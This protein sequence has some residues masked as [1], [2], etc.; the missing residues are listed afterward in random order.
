MECEN[1]TILLLAGFIPSLSKNIMDKLNI[2]SIDLNKLK[3]N[4]WETSCFYYL[5]SGAGT[6]KALVE[7][8]IAKDLFYTNTKDVFN[9]A[10]GK[11]KE[12]PINAEDIFSDE[13]WNSL[14]ELNKY[15][16]INCIQRFLV[17]Y[18]IFNN[19][20]SINASKKFINN[21]KSILKLIGRNT[22]DKDSSQSKNDSYP[23]DFEK[24]TCM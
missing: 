21:I 24:I 18:L 15:I 7:F 23:I 14:D 1:K 5:K 9:Y 4:G 13:F 20:E 16:G 22:D 12:L 11:R 6:G 3:D 8:P 10:F 19:S 2:N 17:E